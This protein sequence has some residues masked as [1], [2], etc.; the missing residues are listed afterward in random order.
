MAIFDYKNLNSQQSLELMNTS[1]NLAVY[2]NIAGY[3]GLPADKFIN[4]LGKTVLTDGI[5]TNK[6]NIALPSGWS[7]VQPTS[8]N[9]PSD[10]L[11]SWGFYPIESPLTGF[12][13]GG[14][15]AKIVEHRDENGKVDQLSVVYAGTNSFV[16]LP[17]YFQINEN[18]IAPNMKPLLDKVKEYAIA[19]N[20]NSEDILITGYSLGAGM[21]NIMAK[22]REQLSDGF[23]A[24]SKYIAHESPYIFEDGNVILNMGFENDVVYRIIGN[25]PTMQ[26]A[27]DSGK[28]GLVNPD[29]KF[30]SSFD[31]IIIFNDTYASPLWHINPFSI[32]NIPVGWN[33][34]A[35]GLTTDAIL[36]IGNSA[37]YEFTDRDS[38]IVV[39]G[40]R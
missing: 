3:L 36:R 5:Y 31:N 32:L 4:F 38:T 24:N 15:Q 21:T 30:D 40:R 12:T 11:D 8:L 7:E 27:I 14:P 18:T 25:E 22:N 20:I 6:I 10:S 17:D 13:K 9:M 23:F 19:N 26:D 34:H 35:S 39:S 29:H 37:F 33:A 2:G 16:D 1:K 28:F